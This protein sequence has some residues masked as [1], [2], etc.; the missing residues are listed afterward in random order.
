MLT[1]HDRRDAGFTLIEMIVTIAVLGVII[2]PLSAMAIVYFRNQG[3]TQA[4]LTA[5]RDAQISATYFAQDVN[6][7]GQRDY[8]T[9]NAQLKATS[10]IQKDA[11]YNEGGITCGSASTPTALVR[12]LSDDYDDTQN[13]QLSVVSYVIES[14]QLHRLRCVR[15]SAT[16]VSDVVL[17]RSLTAAVPILTC[18]SSSTDPVSCTGT[19]TPVKVQ[20]TFI[21]QSDNGSPL[22][23]TLVGAR[24]QTA[25]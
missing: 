2:T 6:A 21:V 14:S 11:A 24:R 17:A 25:T 7:I 4:R 20:L 8:S 1:A 18:F 9:D 12:F 15:G 3:A 13:K 22:T 5:S 10:S 23:I 16:I 19:Q